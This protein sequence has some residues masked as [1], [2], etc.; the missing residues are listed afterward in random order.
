MFDIIL[1]LRQHEYAI[2]ADVEK[3]YRQINIAHDQRNLQRILWRWNA[4]EPIQVF[5]LNTLT[6]GMASS[7]F[8]AIRCFQEIARE[9]QNDYPTASSTI[10]KD[11][12]VDDLLTG[13]QSVED[14]KHLKKDII[15]I[16]NHAKVKIRKWKSNAAEFSDPDSS[17]EA[18][19]TLEE[20]T[21]ILGIL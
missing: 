13:S 9:M 20:P 16:L 5:N 3:M 10:L 15:N 1:R 11:F 7:F 4:Q 21:K 2:A 6:Y 19:V 8:L 12:Y 14:L 17:Q 18:S